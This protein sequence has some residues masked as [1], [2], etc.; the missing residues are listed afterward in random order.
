MHKRVKAVVLWPPPWNQS[1][2]IGKL[3]A[4]AYALLA[5]PLILAVAVLV[6]FT[7]FLAPKDSRN[8]SKHEVANTLERFINDSSDAWEWDDFINGSSLQDE[9]LERIRIQCQQLPSTHPPLE[10]HGYC[11]A[12]GIQ[13]MKQLVLK[14]RGQSQ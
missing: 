10:G 8:L 14:L 5:S 4:Y 12:Q 1:S 3:G 11:S 6:I 13:I 9:S 7:N 2:L